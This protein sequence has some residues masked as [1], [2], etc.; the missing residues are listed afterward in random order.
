MSSC[1][2]VLLK[3]QLKEY[4]QVDIDGMTLNANGIHSNVRSSFFI[5]Q[6]EEDLIT[7]QSLPF[8]TYISDNANG[9]ELTEAAN[10]FLLNDTMFSVVPKWNGTFLLKSHDSKYIFADEN[11]DVLKSE[12]SI[13]DGTWSHECLMGN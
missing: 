3:S 8:A 9:L 12:N 11:G 7:L 5:Q 4:L 2:K 10:G 1:K 6:M 13:E